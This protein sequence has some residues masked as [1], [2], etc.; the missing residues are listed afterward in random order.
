VEAAALQKRPLMVVR[1]VAWVVVVVVLEALVEVV[2][3]AKEILG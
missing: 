2:E 1:V 3:A